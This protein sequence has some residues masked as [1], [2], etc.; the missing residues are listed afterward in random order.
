MHELSI[1]TELFTQINKIIENQP[2]NKVLSITLKVG[3]MQQIIPEAFDFAMEVITKDTKAEGVKIIY[4]EL[5]IIIK[6]NQC[7]IESEVNEF[8]FICEK[9]GSTDVE[10]ISGKELM[11]ESMEVE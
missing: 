8:H 7:N 3:K 5:P 4:K 2:Y 11:F 9:C 1:A 6:C 10:I